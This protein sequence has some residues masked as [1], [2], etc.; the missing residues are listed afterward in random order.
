MAVMTIP[1]VKAARIKAYEALE[2][3]GYD[4]NLQIKSKEEFIK[5]AQDVFGDMHHER[6]GV[7][8]LHVYNGTGGMFVSLLERIRDDSLRTEIIKEVN[9]DDRGPGRRP[10]SNRYPG[11]LSAGAVSMLVLRSGCTTA[12][13]SELGRISSGRTKYTHPDALP[14][15]MKT[16]SARGLFIGSLHMS[17]DPRN[18]ATSGLAAGH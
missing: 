18:A 2:Q 11:K 17:Q 13:I 1:Q 4:P 16:P 3:K 12:D 9:Q 10:S 5:V 15:F 14:D 7:I 8:G 6:P